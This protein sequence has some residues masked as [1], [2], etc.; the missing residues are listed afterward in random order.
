MESKNPYPFRLFGRPD[1]VDQ[2]L[3][4]KVASLLK[5]NLGKEVYKEFKNGEFL[6]HHDESIRD[7]DVYYLFQ[8]RF[9][10]K[11][12]L[13][14]DLDLAE[15]M[16]S[17]IK[18]GEPNRITVVIPCL[19][20]TRQDRPS[21]YREPILVQKIPM[22]LQMAGAN[23]IV[24]LRLHN[25]SSYNAHPLTIPIVNIDTK[26][27]LIEH[28]KSK[29]FDLQ[30][31]KIVSPDLGAAPECR[32]IA[33]ELGIPGNIVIINK[34]HD[35]KSVSKT[36]IMEIIGDPAGYHCIIPDDIG[37]TCGT[38]LKSCIALKEK[39]ALDVYFAIVHAILSGN[40]VENLNEA[41]FSGL[42]FTDTCDFSKKRD[43]INNLEIIS[44]DK[45]IAKV[46]D[47]LH[48]GSSIIDLS[49]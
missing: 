26:K 36:E 17:A 48:N 16:V 1:G 23:R 8:P 15:T 42:W 37:D 32:K 9:G 39:K 40:A 49:R 34:F 38:G 10:A 14:Y 44:S 3:L 30:K 21:N 18:Q 13:S 31:F 24:T 2:I 41:G 19:P 33:Q 46:I 27:L 7:C 22:R 47:N 4:Y 5:V 25:L 35:P 20:Y 12:T 11:E 6:A 29:N 43:L 28:I 45:L